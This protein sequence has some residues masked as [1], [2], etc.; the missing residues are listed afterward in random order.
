MAENPLYTTFPYSRSI[1]V[2]AD[3]TSMCSS[4]QDASKYIHLTVIS[5]DF[6]MISELWS[7]LIIES[8]IMITFTLPFFALGGLK[9]P[10]VVY[11][12]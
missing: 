12:K 7:L 5:A 11:R 8:L 1:K 4:R 10:P 2:M 3:F 9:G 6:T